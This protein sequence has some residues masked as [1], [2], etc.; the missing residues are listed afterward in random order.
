MIFRACPHLRLQRYA[1]V[2]KILIDASKLRFFCLR[3]PCIHQTGTGPSS[4]VFSGDRKGV[5]PFN[6]FFSAWRGHNPSA[7]PDVPLS[8][9]DRKGASPFRFPFFAWRSHA[10]LLLLLLHPSLSY[11]QALNV[12][13][14][15]ADIRISGLQHLTEKQIFSQVTVNSQIGQRAIE[16]V[17]LNDVQRLYLSGYFSAVSAHTVVAT[18]NSMGLVFSVT[19]NAVVRDVAFSGNRVFSDDVLR[20]QLYTRVGRPLNTQDVLRETSRIKTFYHDA[21]YELCQ[22]NGAYLDEED[23]L[24][25]VMTEGQIGTLTLTG[26]DVLP[27]FIFLRE[28]V[29]QPG[30]I[31]NTKTLRED[32]ERLIRLG[33]LGD[34]SSPRLVETPDKQRVNVAMEVQERKFRHLDIGA[35]Q[36]D[37]LPL[38]AFL[39]TDL[40]HTIIPSDYL[41]GKVQVNLNEKSFR[42]YSLRYTQPWLLNWIPLSFTVGM[43]SEVRQEFLTK[44]VQVDNRTLYDISRKGWDVGFGLPLIRDVLTVSTR[45]RSEEVSPEDTA[46]EAYDIRSLGVGVLLRT[47]QNVHNP[48]NGFYW[49]LD[50]EKGG[51]FGGGVNFYRITTNTAA[52]VGLWDGSALGVHFLGGVFQ[53]NDDVDTFEAEGY[54]VGGSMSLRGYKESYPPFV[55]NR[56]LL[57]NTELRQDLNDVVQLVAFY[58]IG[59]AFSDAWS[60]NTDLGTFKSGYGVGIRFFTPLGPLRFDSAWGED[61]ILHF[62]LGQVF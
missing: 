15:I 37:T 14:E 61:W 41:S 17:V 33:F 43:L 38:V 25:F 44:E 20:K 32:R 18:D 62:G 12:F 7:C 51:D 5:S 56:A 23:R 2:K 36:E 39:R 58:D 29:S 10:I 31:L 24:V 30:S 1:Q 13:R 47:Y 26:L 42:G 19:E 59:K 48:K 57:L 49:S 6:V 4:N 22:V 16:G 40:Y 60:N 27:P 8:Q 53:P 54:Q 11:G 3:V 9:G 28:M 21:G 50:A 34:V 46:L 55:G 35:E 52:F 45:F